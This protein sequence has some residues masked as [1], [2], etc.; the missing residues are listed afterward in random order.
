MSRPNV[1][2]TITRDSPNVPVHLAGLVAEF[3]HVSQHGN[4][5]ACRTPLGQQLECR[6]HRRRVGV[7]A[8]VDD[9]DAEMG[10]HL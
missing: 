8:I 5:F 7:V 3:E 4:P 10:H 1:P 9:M 2:Q 6:F